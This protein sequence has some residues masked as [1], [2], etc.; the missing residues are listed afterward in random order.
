MGT[1]ERKAVPVENS[2]S[3]S[4]KAN[5]GEYDDGY[6]EAHVDGIEYVGLFKGVKQI[7]VEDVT[8]IEGKE[9]VHEQGQSQ[10]PNE[11]ND[12]AEGQ[13]KHNLYKGN[14]QLR[15]LKK[16]HGVSFRQ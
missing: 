2:I 5:D 1:V 12:R 8:P 9:V 7:S 13:E 14:S 11:K 10:S 16:L 3:V 15:G 6:S 4:Q